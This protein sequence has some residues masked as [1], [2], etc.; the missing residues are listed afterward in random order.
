MSGADSRL[1][2]RFSAASAPPGKLAAM[3]EPREQRDA[4]GGA[5]PATIRRG[6]SDGAH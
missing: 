6:F 1:Q 5:M 4:E 2:R 3:D